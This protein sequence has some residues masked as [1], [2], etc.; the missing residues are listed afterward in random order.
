[1]SKQ[2]P[3]RPQTPVSGSA[4]VARQGLDAAFSQQAEDDERVARN[5][6]DEAREDRGI[7]EDAARS[8]LSELLDDADFEALVRNQ[9]EQTALPTP[10]AMPGWHLCWLTTNSQYDSLQKRHRIGYRPVRRAELPG[11][12]PQG[13]QQVAGEF[14]DYV[15]CNEM[16]LHKIP[17]KYYQMMMSYFH[18]KRPLE[19][20]Q[21]LTRKIRDGN[22]AEQDSAGKDLG[23]ILGAGL[24]E[25]ET[26]ARRDRR[27]PRF[28]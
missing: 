22:E 16:V 15:T 3:Q 14:A 17:E 10:P 21:S 26:S 11:F 20:V 2:T 28:S 7:P 6:G 25:L 27:M 13:G 12:Q 1:M 19:D 24:L 18:H 8:D 5:V 23:E 9:F 4:P